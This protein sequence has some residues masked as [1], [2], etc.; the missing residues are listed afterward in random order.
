M[1]LFNINNVASL[2]FITAASFSSMSGASVI[3]GGDLLDQSGANLLEGYLGTGDLD[4]TNISNLHGGAPASWW[5]A[6]VSGYTDVISIYDIY[7]NGTQMLLGGYSSIGHDG[8][9]ATHMLGAANTNF[10]FNLSTG[11]VRYSTNL[12][13]NDH[14]DQYDDA[15]YS[16][17]LGTSRGGQRIRIYT[18]DMAF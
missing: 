17:R 13:V 6:D 2:L 18:S 9:G 5:H 15:N 14:N 8:T 1:K 11:V 3:T 16:R 12:G 7:Y 10:I 4:F